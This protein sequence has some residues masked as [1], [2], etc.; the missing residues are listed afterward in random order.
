MRVQVL[1]KAMTRKISTVHK[2]LVGKEV[3]MKFRLYEVIWKHL[4]T[5]LYMQQRTPLRPQ[6]IGH[7]RFKAASM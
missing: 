1:R 6:M 2:Q 3:G 4:Y 5:G 7:G